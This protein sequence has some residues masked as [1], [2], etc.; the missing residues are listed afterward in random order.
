MGR[1]LALLATVLALPGLLSPGATRAGQGKAKVKALTGRVTARADNGI[2]IQIGK[3]GLPPET[4]KVTVGQDSVLARFDK[5]A[6][7][8]LTEGYLVAVVGERNGDKL[9]AQG[10]LRLDKVEGEPKRE[11]WIHAQTMARLMARLVRP[12]AKPGEPK[13][14]P[15]PPLVGRVA[16]T[17]PLSVQTDDGAKVEVQ[18]ANTTRVVS[19]SQLAL[20]DIREGASVLVVPTEEPQANAATARALIE[21]PA[22]AGKRGHRKQQA[23]P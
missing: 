20:A 7:A 9:S 3:K 16:G 19:Q 22:R 6:V 8:D 14:K 23:K 5:A 15:E 2:E 1:A 21:L 18:T 4:L 17:Q 10:I 13:R 11:D 12:A